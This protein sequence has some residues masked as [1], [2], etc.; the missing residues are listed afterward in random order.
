MSVTLSLSTPVEYALV[1]KFS[2]TP[3]KKI[4]KY[5]FENC[6]QITCNNYQPL[7]LE[8][9]RFKAK[10]ISKEDCVIWLKNHPNVSQAEAVAKGEEFDWFYGLDC[11]ET[12]LLP[13]GQQFLKALNIDAIIRYNGMFSRLGNIN[14]GEFRVRGIRWAKNDLDD[15]ND[16]IVLSALEGQMHYQYGEEK[17]QSLLRNISVSEGKPKKLL[18]QESATKGFEEKEGCRKFT[19]FVA[20]MITKTHHELAST[21]NADESQK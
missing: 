14:P 9:L 19:Q 2:E 3:I 11:L 13:E 16:V 4:P 21:L 10:T 6:N 1:P 8:A 15:I 5:L 20:K 7:Y 18:F 17:A 12:E